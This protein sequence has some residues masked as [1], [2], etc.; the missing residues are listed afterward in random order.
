MKENF[1]RDLAD[2]LNENSATLPFVGIAISFVDEVFFWEVIYEAGK[3]VGFGESL[4]ECFKQIK[5]IAAMG[6]KGASMAANID[7]LLTSIEQRAAEER[8]N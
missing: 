8:T 5:E 2:W 4:G 6:Q 3:L 1:E 7:N